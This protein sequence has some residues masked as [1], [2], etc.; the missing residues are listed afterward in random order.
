MNIL[1]IC[2]TFRPDTAIAAKRPFMFA[3]YLTELGHSVTVI[4]SGQISKSIDKTFNADSFNFKV[5][6]YTGGISL[7][8]KKLSKRSLM[9][10]PLPLSNLIFKIVHAVKIPLI[11]YK[12]NKGKIRHFEMIKKVVDG[13]EP[14]S[15]DIVFSTYGGLANVLAGK[16][17]KEKLGCKWVQDFR[18]RIVQ[19]GNRSWLWN[20]T[21]SKT[22][23]HAYNEADVITAVSDDLFNGT[24]YPKGKRKTIYNGYNR[25]IDAGNTSIKRERD[26]SICYTGSLP[27]NTLKSVKQLF[28]ELKDMA[29]EKLIDLSRLKINFVG[30]EGAEFKKIAAQYGLE[31]TIINHGYLDLEATTNVQ[32]GSDLFLVLSQNT[33]KYQGV[34][35]GKFYEGIRCGMP[36]LSVIY[37]NMPNSELYRLNETYHYGFCY[38]TCRSDRSNSFRK[39]FLPLYQSKVKHGKIDFPLSQELRDKFEYEH[40]TKELETIFYNLISEKSAR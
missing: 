31:K 34:L 9:F 25:I 36:I 8:T 6:S 23:K 11:V 27:G 1:I 26:F 24:K 40:L 13:F 17:A 12:A 14:K 35:T 32:K 28:A 19:P 39:F 20:I 16:Y 5:I 38:E 37:G 3:K 4:W 30:Q 10:L 18:D 21:F 2:T 7:P 22:E 29:N 33:K 15:F